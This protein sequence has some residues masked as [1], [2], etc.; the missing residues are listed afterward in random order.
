[1]NSFWIILEKY[2]MIII[3]SAFFLL[4]QS[5]NIFFYF[6]C[7]NKLFFLTIALSLEW[8]RFLRFCL[9]DLR[10]DDRLTYKEI[11]PSLNFK[12]T[13]YLMDDKRWK[14][15]HTVSIKSTIPTWYPKCRRN[16]KISVYSCYIFDVCNS[17]QGIF[18]RKINCLMMLSSHIIK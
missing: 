13:R 12:A 3:I 16:R 7:A 18:K 8:L 5:T 14:P 9:R 17:L 10:L 4:C 11:F 2:E 15:C 6:S 1:M